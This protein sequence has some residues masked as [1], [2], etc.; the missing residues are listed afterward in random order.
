MLKINH[1]NAEC[2]CTFSKA[3]CMAARYRYVHGISSSEIVKKFAFSSIFK[4][5]EELLTCFAKPKNES[6]LPQR[7]GARIALE[8]LFS[9]MSSGLEL[10]ESCLRKNIKGVPESDWSVV[11][12]HHLLSKLAVSSFYLID[13]SRGKQNRCPCQCGESLTGTYGDSSIGSPEVWHGLLDILMSVSVKFMS[14]EDPDSLSGSGGHYIVRGKETDLKSIREQIIAQSIVFSFFQ[15]KLHP[16]YVHHLIPS[17]G[18]S[19]DMLVVYLYD[20]NND[21][22]LESSEMPYLTTQGALVKP[23]IVALWLVLNYEFLC[24]GITKG[25]NDSGVKSNFTQ[26][27]HEK[28]KLYD[29]VTVPCDS[30]CSGE[31]EQWTWGARPENDEPA[32]RFSDVNMLQPWKLSDSS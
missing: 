10:T 15:R 2:P 11:V 16:E 14:F 4:Y 31:E 7:K 19:K 22:L 24:S 30:S 26:L 9:F 5:G 8:K 6:R 28:L 25:M 27:V 12:A 17:I 3:Y 23:T 20:C 18:I 32:Q 21:I 29:K 1:C 13:Q